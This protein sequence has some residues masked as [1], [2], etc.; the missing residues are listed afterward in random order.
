[1]TYGEYRDLPQVLRETVDLHVTDI[2]DAGADERAIVFSTALAATGQKARYYYLGPEGTRCCSTSN[3]LLA[4]G[5][6]VR[7]T[8]TRFD[9]EAVVHLRTEFMLVDGSVS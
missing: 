6:P 2:D 1:M 7:A 5:Q 8:D 4:N 9:G 3:V